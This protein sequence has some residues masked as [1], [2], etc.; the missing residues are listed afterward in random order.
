MHEAIEA[1]REVKTETPAAEPA[2]AG[3][4]NYEQLIKLSGLKE[5]GI[6]WKRNSR[7]KKAN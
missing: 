5:S 2:V 3:L 1:G 6:I 4:A 7:R